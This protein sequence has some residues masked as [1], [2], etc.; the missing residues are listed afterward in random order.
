MKEPPVKDI[1]HKILEEKLGL[2][3]E[4]LKGKVTKGV[5]EPLAK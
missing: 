5:H 1:V 4:T 3:A 2:L